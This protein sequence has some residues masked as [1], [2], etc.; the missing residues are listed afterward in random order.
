[1]LLS[2]Q[3]LFCLIYTYPLNMYY[4]ENKLCSSHDCL[5]INR[6]EKVHIV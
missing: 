1:M 2:S 3:F 4:V 5:V 6:R